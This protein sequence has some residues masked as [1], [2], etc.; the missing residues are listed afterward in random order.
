MII[1]KKKTRGQ[2]NSQ[3]VK[4]I[5]TGMDISFI[6]GPNK[7]QYNLEEAKVRKGTMHTHIH[8]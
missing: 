2:L 5:S 4:V 1:T 6:Q 3:N 7:P 8:A